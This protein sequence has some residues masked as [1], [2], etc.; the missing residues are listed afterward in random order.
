MHPPLLVCFVLSQLLLF[1]RVRCGCQKEFECGSLGTM[2]FPFS[3]VSYKDC[4]FF[5]VNCSAVPHPTVKLWAELDWLFYILYQNKSILR[6]Q[7]PFKNCNSFVQEFP[8]NSAISLTIQS[9]VTMLKCNRNKDGSYVDN[10]V[11][12]SSNKFGHCEE[13]YFF[14]IYHNYSNGRFFNYSGSVP[15]GCSIIKLPMLN[16]NF[17]ADVNKEL[18]NFL[19]D[20]WVLEWNLSDSCKSCRNRGG[21]CEVDQFNNF[22]CSEDNNSKSIILITVFGALTCSLI[23]SFIIIC[24]IWRRKKRITGYSSQVSRSTSFD[25]SSNPELESGI[26]F[27]VPIYSYKEL[28]DA[29]ENFNSS[30]ELGDGGFGTVYH[31]KLKDGREVAVKLLHAHNYKRIEHFMNEIRILTSLRHP[32]LVSLYGCTSRHSREL[33]LVYEFVSNGTVADHLYGNQEN[34]RSLT[35]AIRMSIALETAHALSYLHK[36]DIIHRDIKT[37]NILLDDKFSVKVADFGLSRLIPN[38]VT[39]ISTA[40]QGTPGYVD[41]QYHECCQLTDK[42]DVY[43][44][45][46]VLI[47]LISS[48]P[49]VDVNR[50]RLEITLAN[51]AI[52]RIQNNAVDELI[53]PSLGHDSDPEVKRMAN[54]IAELAFC[55]LQHEK[56]MRPTMD[57]ALEALKAIK[58]DKHCNGVQRRKEGPPFESEEAGLLRKLKSSPTSPVSVANFWISGSSATNC[59]AEKL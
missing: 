11:V 33:L 9:N 36:S 58:D 19:A 52:S 28:K 29:T 50:H 22:K 37:T 42:S 20:E 27:G 56:E 15:L 41:P 2:S 14:D 51:L 5:F 38:D 55:C 7:Y 10:W 44:F 45:G 6:I 16:P 13:N 23:I 54:G 18:F 53:D 24:I 39:H 31:G 32:N 43:S 59:S 26:Y 3:N 46:V 34:Y 12:P 47:E 8:N 1:Y 35:W 40:P 48:L 21:R 49:A 4:G 57:E 25:P 17:S 30:K